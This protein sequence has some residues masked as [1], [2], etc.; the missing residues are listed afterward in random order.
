MS[1]F[2]VPWMIGGGQA[3]HAADLGRIVAHAAFGGVEG[4]VGPLDLRILPLS[5][6]GGAVRGMPG[7]CAVLNRS[8]GGD[9]QMYVN[10]NTQAV[11]VLINPTTSTGPRSDLVVAQ[12]MDPYAAGEGWDVPADPA[13][14]PYM[15]FRVIEGVSPSTTSVAGTGLLTS[16]IALA[17]IDL[18]S[19][20]GTVESQHIKDLRQVAGSSTRLGEAVDSLAQRSWTSVQALA[21]PNPGGTLLH[22]NTTYRTW[23]DE[24][25]WDV[26]IPSW[27][28]AA[29]IEITL[30]PALANGDFWGDLRVGLGSSGT[31]YVTLGSAIDANYEADVWTKPMVI[32]LIAGG[33][34]NVPSS[35]RGTVQRLF[36]QAKSNDSASHTGDLYA[37][38]GCVVSARVDF[39][40]IPSLT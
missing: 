33:R 34:V 4:V 35:M 24:A 36:L 28:T 26:P 13:N 20:T 23:P 21:D 12:V 8:L 16:A 15:A 40:G 25:D 27:A 18:P 1:F 39:K 32:Q 17:R 2:G 10:R 11:D 31:Q 19:S 3:Q 22:T 5:T 9:G 29:D 14:G 37:G 30:S 38:R 7:T 6:P